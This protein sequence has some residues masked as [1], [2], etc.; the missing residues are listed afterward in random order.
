MVAFGEVPGG[1]DAI[2]RVPDDGDHAED[3]EGEVSNV[4]EAPAASGLGDA[5]VFLRVAG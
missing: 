3:V 4:G 2:G 5:Q 1:V